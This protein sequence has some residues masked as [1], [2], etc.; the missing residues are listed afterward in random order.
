M[1]KYV[2]DDF[3]ADYDSWYQTP[4]GAFVDRVETDCA[5]GLRLEV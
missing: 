2:F 5:L 3:Y 4:M 1:S